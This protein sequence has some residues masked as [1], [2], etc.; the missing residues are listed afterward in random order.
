M[1]EDAGA[2]LPS[3]WWRGAFSVA[4]F[5]LGGWL[6]FSDI[7]A[8]WGRFGSLVNE[9]TGLSNLIAGLVLI[10]GGIAAIKG[11]R[12]PNHIYFAVT[13]M[14]LLVSATSLAFS[15]NM[16][17]HF[18]YLHLYN[19]IGCLVFWLVFI[20]HRGDRLGEL[21]GAAFVLP[22]SYLIIV[23]VALDGYYPFLNKQTY[24][25]A[26]VLTYIGVSTLFI[27]AAAIGLVRI[28]QWFHSIVSRAASEPTG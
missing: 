15:L 27:V 18:A 22:V 25:P 12:L 16:T 24:G 6:V 20:D 3:I 10:A 19:S 14:L 1:S 23:L 4:A 2:R 8:Y 11:R 26:S 9:L 28:N 5:L 17:G 21:L 7:S 13:M